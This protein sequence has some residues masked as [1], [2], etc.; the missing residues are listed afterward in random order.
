M[1]THIKT[2]AQKWDYWKRKEAEA[3][4]QRRQAEDELV[5]MLGVIDTLEQS[6]THKPE[7]G[8][9]INV[10]TRLNH[11]VNGDELQAL[12][13]ELGLTAHIGQ[14][15]RWKPDIN[16]KAWKAADKSITGALAPAITTTAS[17]PSFK[18]TFEE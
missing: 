8:L 2:L 18:I 17:R 14:L 16:A 1:T 9:K 11:R 4:D 10:T 6:K 3:V 12:A 15:F 13:A 5:K 7:P